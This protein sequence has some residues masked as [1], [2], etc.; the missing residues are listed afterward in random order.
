[1]L[2]DCLVLGDPQKA[3]RNEDLDEQSVLVCTRLVL[4]N[5]LKKIKDLGDQRLL[6]CAWLPPSG[7]IA[8]NSD[9]LRC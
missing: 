2:C 8:V 9:E 4:G 3:K 1:M 5:P 6:P 7:E